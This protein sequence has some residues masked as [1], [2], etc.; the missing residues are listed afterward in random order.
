M[1]K[2]LLHKQYCV[3]SFVRVCPHLRHGS[4]R[5]SHLQIV[6]SGCSDGVKPVHNF[7]P[8][9]TIRGSSFRFLIIET[10]IN[11]QA[12]LHLDQK[13]FDWNCGQQ[14]VKFNAGL[15]TRGRNQRPHLSILVINKD[16]PRA[17]VLQVGDLQPVGGPDLGW[18][19]CRVH[20]TD[21]HH[22]FR[23]SGLHKV[24][25]RTAR[26]GVFLTITGWNCWAAFPRGLTSCLLKYFNTPSRSDRMNLRLRYWP[27]SLP[28]FHRNPSL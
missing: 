22:R 16:I 1:E 5:K 9:N 7:L 8:E 14:G 11:G 10:D 12:Q 15:S 23:L 4:N 21:L 27:L 19:E 24:K 25:K 28:R 2:V 17:V 3:C 26:E 13:R 6:K 18:L 20:G